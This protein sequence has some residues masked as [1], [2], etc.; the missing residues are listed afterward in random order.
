[1]NDKEP[2]H[3]PDTPGLRWRWRNSWEAI[4]RARADIVKKGFRPKNKLLWKGN[5]ALTDFEVKKLQDECQS[6]Q[7]E[8]LTHGRGGIPDGVY[9]GT[10]AS[11]IHCYRTDED[12]TFRKLRFEV[13]KNQDHT[14][15]RIVD[16]HGAEPV[17]QINARTLLRWHRQWSSNGQKIAIAHAFIGHLR[18]LTSFGMTILEDSE[19]ARLKTILSEMSFPVSKPRTER[20]TADQAIAIRAQAHKFGWPSI[21]LAQ[22]FQFE[23]MLRQKDVIGEWVPLTE[24]G[25]SAVT[26]RRG[27]WLRGLRWEEIDQNLILRHTTSK[28][29]KDIAVN[30]RDDAPMVM[31]ELQAYEAYCGE[32]PTS[33]PIC[34]CEATARAWI[35]T[36]FRRKWRIVA[37]AAGIPDAVRSMDSRAGA[38]TEAV[39]AGA[40]LDQIRRTAT[41]SDLKT[42]M[43]YNRAG[44]A[45]SS[46][47]VSQL[48]I[49]K[50]KNP[51]GTEG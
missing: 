11:L 29:L 41:H 3:I 31:E 26:S 27:K 25:L 44:Y 47:K 4:W 9:N 2:P 50:R 22:A 15:R 5:R 28:K 36:E 33:G 42:T 32:L 8:M 12:S 24:P 39:E 16:N 20:M 21:A 48:R 40:D 17:S 7:G 6:L 35:A 46:A 19:C 1:M 23:L 38:I 51:T 34:I 45:D 49:A 14:L 43:G 37:R 10:L 30:L 13:R 18:T